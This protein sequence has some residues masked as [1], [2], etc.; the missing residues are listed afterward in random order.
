MESEPRRKRLEELLLIIGGCEAAIRNNKKYKEAYVHSYGKA[1]E[2][3]QQQ[4]LKKL[5]RVMNGLP[6]DESNA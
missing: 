4:Y 3:M 2:K 5:E 6:E 1:F